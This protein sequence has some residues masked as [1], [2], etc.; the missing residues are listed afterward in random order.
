MDT[1]VLTG[2]EHNNPIAAL[3]GRDIVCGSES[4]LYFH[5]I[6]YFTQERDMRM[7]FEE[8]GDN[9]ALLDRYRVEYVYISSYERADFDLD[10]AWFNANC[11]TVFAE[12]DVC[13]YRKRGVHWNSTQN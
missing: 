10:E 8:P 13:L 4:Y 9:L 7:M 5:G 1:V 3:A 2:R 6:S 11:D 12:G